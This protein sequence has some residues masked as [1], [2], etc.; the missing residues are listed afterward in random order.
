[1]S[2]KL[3]IFALKALPFALVSTFFIFCA[4]FQTFYWIVSC[5]II[6]TCII[7]IVTAAFTWMTTIHSNITNFFTSTFRTIFKVFWILNNCFFVVIYTSKNNF[8]I[9]FIPMW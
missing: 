4:R 1:M 2:F 8:I 6:L 7:I 3:S 5:W 9:D